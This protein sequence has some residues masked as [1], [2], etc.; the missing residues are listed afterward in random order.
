M[1]KVRRCE[2]ARVRRC[3][4]KVLRASI[5]ALAIA[6]P[7]LAAAKVG[8]DVLKTRNPR[9]R[10]AARETGD[11]VRREVADT[12][13]RQVTVAGIQPFDSS[14]WSAVYRRARGRSALR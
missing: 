1:F 12:P 11:L 10:L 2:G 13:A 14:A 3:W 7:S 6:S 8:D 5:L 9:V 4:C